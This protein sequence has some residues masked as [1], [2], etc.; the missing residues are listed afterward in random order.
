MQS[1]PWRVGALAYKMHASAGSVDLGPVS[2]G[3]VSFM[4]ARRLHQRADVDRF[5]ERRA[6][7]LVAMACEPGRRQPLIGYSTN[8]AKSAQMTH[9]KQAGSGLLLRKLTNSPYSTGGS[10]LI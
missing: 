7:H 4:R 9:K 8:T 3:P 5:L 6:Q 1:S 10:F 2:C